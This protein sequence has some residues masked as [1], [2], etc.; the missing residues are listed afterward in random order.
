MRV[1]VCGG[2]DY[3]AA[4]SLHRFMDELARRTDTVIEGDARGADRM[5]GEWARH[6][7]MENTKF[8]ADWE[9]LGSK[10]GPIRNQ[11][12]LDE[13]RVQN[14]LQNRTLTAPAEPSL[15]RWNVCGAG[16]GDRTHD[17]KLGKLAFYH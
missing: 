7:G 13:R 3:G 10:A 5:A 17:I 8:C 12:M 16:D 4:E 9:N 15:T 2:R 14:H 11:L 6:R 1:L